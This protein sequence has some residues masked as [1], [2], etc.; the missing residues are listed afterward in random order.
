MK[1]SI[2]RLTIQS[3]E[4]LGISTPESI[5]E[6]LNKKSNKSKEFYQETVY[7]IGNTESPNPQVFTYPEFVDIRDVRYK[8]TDTDGTIAALPLTN[9]DYVI[10][11][12]AREI[13]VTGFNLP[14]ASSI[15][16]K[17]RDYSISENES[18]STQ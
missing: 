17:G 6:K 18:A 2:N 10:N 14:D 16:L 7:A 12:E 4:A 15:I 3:V 11:K 1:E 13:T 9:S 8:E 5:Q